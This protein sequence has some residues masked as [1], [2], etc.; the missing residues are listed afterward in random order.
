MN[1]M[2]SRGHALA[3]DAITPYQL[4]CNLLRIKG[5]PSLRHFPITFARSVTRSPADLSPSGATAQARH[6]E[7]G[8]SA[9]PAA[10]LE[11]EGSVTMH[12]GQNKCANS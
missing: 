1:G 9:L 4:R 11:D 12:G 7:H 5:R 10:S 6:V 8:Q 2:R 3:S